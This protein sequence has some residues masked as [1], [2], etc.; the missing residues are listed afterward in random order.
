LLATGLAD[1]EIMK[2]IRNKGKERVIDLA[3]AGF[4][5]GNHLDMMTPALSLF[6]FAELTNQ[7]LRFKTVKA[8]YIMTDR[9]AYQ[10]H[11]FRRECWV[12]NATGKSDLRVVSPNLC[13]KLRH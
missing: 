13:Y 3:R 11:N 2:L 8:Y 10:C 12:P 4:E 1:D 6:A 5:E 9:G 7:L